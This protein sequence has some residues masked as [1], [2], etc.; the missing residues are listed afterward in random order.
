MAAALAGEGLVRSGSSMNWRATSMKDMWNDQPDAFPRSGRQ[1]EEEEELKWA[2]MERLPT[3]E[4]LKKGM[5]GHV[6]SN[7]R[8]VHDEVDVTKLAADDKKKLMDSILKVVEE[9]NEKFLRKLRDRTDRLV[10]SCL[11]CSFHSMA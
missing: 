9:D 11:M 7:G 5:L 10:C 6:M 4:R 1:E 3:Y 8:I 2:A